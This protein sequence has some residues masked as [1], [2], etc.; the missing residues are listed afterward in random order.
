MNA[1]L[2][3][4]LVVDQKSWS[5]FGITRPFCSRGIAALSAA[6]AERDGVRPEAFSRHVLNAKV[7]TGPERRTPK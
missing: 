4:G 5:N 3:L 7:N 6:L 2:R 1:A